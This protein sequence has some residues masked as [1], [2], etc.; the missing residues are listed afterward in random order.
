MPRLPLLLLPPALVA[1][2]A[3]ALLWDTSSLGAASHE[4]LVQ[5]RL[6]RLLLAAF[7]GSALALAGLLMQG[8]F[9]NPLVEPGLL[10][11]SA[12]AGLGAVIIISAGFGGLWLLPLAAFAGALGT[13]GLVLAIGRRLSGQ[14]AELL[15]AGV[16]LNALAGALV[17]LLLSLG[18]PLTLRSATFWLLGSFGQAEWALLLPA[19]M[20]LALVLAWGWRQRRALDVWQL[21]EAEA[22][23]LGLSLTRFRRQLLLAASLLVA[24]AVAQSGGIGFVGLLAPHMARRLG[25]FR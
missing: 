13:L 7:T 1:A 21:G 8:F 16:A 18:D 9:R 20:L 5:L 24:L 15:L 22:V 17:N 25:L 10:G 23:H 6:P 2:P 19:W 11:V 12:G 4:V 3:L 14:H